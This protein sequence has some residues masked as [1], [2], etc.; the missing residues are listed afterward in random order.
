M[1]GVE[2][3]SGLEG[4]AGRS[5]TLS[6]CLLLVVAVSASLGVAAARAPAALASCT[7]GVP[8]QGDDYRGAGNDNGTRAF[9]QGS[10]ANH[11]CGGVLASVALQA[12]PPNSTTGPFGFIQTGY[13]MESASYASD[14]DPGAPGETL[15]VTEYATNSNPTNFICDVDF[16]GQQSL[17]G[18]GDTFAVALGNNGWETF[19]DSNKDDTV[20]G[21]GYNS[22]Y[23]V[24]R[25][26]AKYASTT[27]DY[28]VTWGPSGQEAWQ[29][30]TDPNGCCTTYTNVPS[31]ANKWQ[32]PTN[33][34]N[35]SVGSTPSPFSI[36][37]IR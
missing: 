17:F 36:K 3:E 8:T 21:L 20:T 13:L 28:N 22:G 29:Y 11:S 12:S 9:I 15:V 37:F 31:G 6:R 25:G 27:P 14:C 32:Y 19:F 33:A 18:F 4:P 10:A 26:E 30:K 1:P 5:L 35:W 16:Q 7:T 34:N 24:A 2:V 23:S